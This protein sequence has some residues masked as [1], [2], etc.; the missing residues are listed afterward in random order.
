MKIAVAS[1]GKWLASNVDFHTG[2]A[3]CFIV[4]DTGEESFAV[5]DNWLCTECVHWAGHQAATE[6]IDA[7]IEAVIV[8][9]IGPNTFRRLTDQNISIF[10]TEET[11]VVKAIRRFRE[12][13]LSLADE[14]NCF[15]HVHQA[16]SKAK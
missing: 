8:R 9:N 13:K 10:Y 5:I 14:P 4:Y 3:E 7:G 11:T 16:G 12:G 1:S 15:G 6:L 2:R